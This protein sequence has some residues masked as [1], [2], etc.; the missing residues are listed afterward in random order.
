MK[1]AHVA[2][3]IA[4]AAL[5]AAGTLVFTA[6]DAPE[7]RLA[8]PLE[9]LPLH[10]G[11]WVADGL[12]PR[13]AFV[14]D[15]RAADELMR[16][17]RRADDVLWVSVAHYPYQGEGRRAAA[18]E[19][20]LPGHT[21][22]VRDERP[23]TIRAPGVENGIID[24]R[25]IVL[26]SP[27]WR[28]SVIYWYQLPGRTTASDHQYRGLLLYNRLLYH[29][30]DAALVRVAAPLHPSQPLDAAVSAQLD[31]VQAFYGPL[32][33]SLQRSRDDRGGRS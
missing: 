2:S 33:A 24:A 29:R 21:W 4:M 23:L 28:L 3:A 7:R 6:A 9:T 8:A 10:A 16:V 13:E 19:L 5:A 17:Y 32:R 20:M 25:Y 1:Q 27:F 30:A 12:P 11:H 26:E 14:P 22:S 15:A 18:R 31:F